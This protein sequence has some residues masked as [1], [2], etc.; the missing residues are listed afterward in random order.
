MKESTKVLFLRPLLF[1]ETVTV[2]ILMPIVVFFFRYISES[3][4]KNFLPV[5]MGASVAANFGLILGTMTKYILIRPAI[6]VMEKD[7]YTPAEIYRAVRSASLL[8]LVESIV[9]FLRFALF[10][11]LM[12]TLPIYLKGYIRLPEFL[13]G[14]NSV[15]MIGLLAIP[16]IYLASEN[17]LTPFYMK[18][19][20]K[21]VLDSNMRFFRLSLSQKNLITILLIAIP[22]LGLI[23][24]LLYLSMATGLN[25]ASLQ[26]GF[27]VILF[28]TIILSFV[29]GILLMKN[30][31]I[32]VGRMSVMFQD[33]AKGQGD[34]T[35]RLEVNG[36][37]EVGELSFWFNEFMGDIEQVV[38]HVRDTSLELHQAIEDVS[39]G[40]R[41]L[42][43]ATQDQAA[44]VEEISASIEEMNSTI[45]NNA[46]L[47]NEGQDASSAIT[48]LIDQSKQVFAELM[49]AIQGI[50]LDSRK[51]GDIV[52]TVN[53]VAFHTNLLALNASVEAARAG[54]HGKGFAVVAGEVRSLA[55]RSA[56]AASEIKA[57][58]DGTVS[59]IKNGDEMMNKT[60]SSLEELMSRMEFFFRMMETIST[61]SMEQTQNIGELSRAI[62]QID[63][64]TQNN[65]TTVEELASTM[66]NLRS[67]AT[68]LAEDVQKFKTSQT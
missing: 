59:R 63:H 25:I 21:G 29:C 34:L 23:L 11:N 47:I 4:M 68:T 26:M 31:S 37:N 54:E 51:I 42:S 13:F 48:K 41:G 24:G 44:N 15:A 30:L 14:V 27:Y 65:A 3:V 2:A 19:N 43:Q 56:G 33:M 28:E 62:S 64:S 49:K 9:I 53:E 5:I 12:A 55:Q 57:L 67:M 40:S 32:S 52:L 39:S 60:S 35:K 20:L 17:S 22:P 1:Q 16:I 61:S 50:S 10:G 46:N 58:I 8:P 18:S 45:Q 66:D 6:E 7:S 38:G 36:L